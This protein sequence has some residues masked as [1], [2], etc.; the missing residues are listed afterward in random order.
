MKVKSKARTYFLTVS[1]FIVQKFFIVVNTQSN[2]L[3][4]QLLGGQ[5]CSP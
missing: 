5:L 3:R 2:F 4:T 1:N